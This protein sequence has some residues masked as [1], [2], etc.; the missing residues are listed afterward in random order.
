[1]EADQDLA[2][3]A[4]LQQIHHRGVATRNEETDIAAC[5]LGDH[6]SE[7]LGML[8]LRDAL[9]VLQC[10]SARCIVAAK[11]TSCCSNWRP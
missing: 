5:S 4:V 9:R 2:E 8:Q 3:I 11:K 7:R 10:V 6:R 1:M